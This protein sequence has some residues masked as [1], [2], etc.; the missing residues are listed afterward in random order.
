VSHFH[1]SGET[2]LLV[3]ILG[4]HAGKFNSNHC[5]LVECN[6]YK[7]PHIEGWIAIKSL[8]SGLPTNRNDAA[9]I[10]TH[11]IGSLGTNSFVRCYRSR[12]LLFR[13]RDF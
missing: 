8:K 10:K 2:R 4:Y 1:A 12:L 7:F 11:A 5:Y 6:T 3:E 9:L 13:R